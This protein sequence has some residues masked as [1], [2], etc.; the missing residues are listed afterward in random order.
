MTKNLNAVSA[1]VVSLFPILSSS[2]QASYCYQVLLLKHFLTEILP[3]CFTVFRIKPKLLGRSVLIRHWIL[4]HTLLTFLC[5]ALA[6]PILCCSWADGGEFA[7]SCT[8]YTFYCL[9]WNA[10]LLSYWCNL[11]FNLSLSIATT[12]GISLAFSPFLFPLSS[13]RIQVPIL[14][15]P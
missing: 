13:R 5:R 6:L 7:Y 1:E 3:R 9:V 15:F 10:L 4:V 14:C 11:E 2:V 8:F 12:Q